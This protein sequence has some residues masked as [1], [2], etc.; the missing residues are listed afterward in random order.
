[1]AEDGSPAWKRVT[2]R[3]IP[4]EGHPDIEGVIV[5]KAQPG[6]CYTAE[7][8]EDIIDKM[9]ERLDQRFPYWNFKMI[10]LGP[11]RVNF[12]YDGLRE[13]A[14]DAKP[15][16]AVESVPTGDIPRD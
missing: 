12:V 9:I 16:D 5:A 8:V 13:G 15:S 4:P 6:R 7:A 14:S 2:M 10:R 1:M 3:V 11:D